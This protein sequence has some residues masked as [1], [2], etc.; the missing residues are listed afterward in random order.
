MTPAD[1]DE[2]IEWLD[3]L[4]REALRLNEWMDRHADA[5][6]NVRARGFDALPEYFASAIDL[7]D[8][9]MAELTDARTL[10]WET[11]ERLAQLREETT[12]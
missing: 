1:L 10:A 12:R 9:L 6:L 11:G 5:E 4:A 2:A 3:A 7:A 8:R